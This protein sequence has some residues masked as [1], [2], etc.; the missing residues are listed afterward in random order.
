M[1]KEAKAIVFA[2]E[3]AARTVIHS[4]FAE[5]TAREVLKKKMAGTLRPAKRQALAKLRVK[6][7]EAEMALAILEE[8]V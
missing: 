8:E 6:L 1:T 2:A 7:A 5:G 4:S 3:L